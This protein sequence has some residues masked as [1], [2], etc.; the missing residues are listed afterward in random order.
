MVKCVFF[1][2]KS[3]VKLSRYAMQAPMERSDIAL[4]ILDL[5]T[6]RGE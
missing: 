6:S 1:E 4:F 2:V 3:K 5:G